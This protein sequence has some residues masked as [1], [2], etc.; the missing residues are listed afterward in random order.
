M[1]GR[2]GVRVGR[3]GAVLGR[4][5]GDAQPGANV[6]VRIAEPL[7]HVAIGAVV[8]GAE[9]GLQ[10]GERELRD[11][12]PVD[13]AQPLVAEEGAGAAGVGPVV[14]D[15]L[16]GLE[17]LP[18]VR[19]G[20][21][22]ACVAKG[23]ERRLYVRLV[24]EGA[25]EVDAAAH[26]AHDQRPVAVGEQ[27]LEEGRRRDRVRRD[28]VLVEEGGKLAVRV[29]AVTVLI[30][31]V[32][33]AR[34]ERLQRIE[35]VLG[36]EDAR[37]E[38]G[39]LALQ[40]RVEVPD[41]DPVALRRHQVVGMEE[42]V[43][44]AVDRDGVVR[45]RLRAV[46]QGADGGH[47]HGAD[48]AGKPGRIERL[49]VGGARLAERVHDS[50]AL[51]VGERAVG[52]RGVVGERARDGVQQVRHLG[53][54]LD[55]VVG[56]GLEEVAQNVQHAA[57][58]EQRH[59]RDAVAHEGVVGVVPL[60]PLGVHPDAALGDQI[61]QLGEHRHQELLG[62]RHEADL[63]VGVP[64]Q[65]AVRPD[66]AHAALDLRLQVGVEH[67][68][69]VRIAEQVGVRLDAVRD[70][71][72]AEEAPREEPFQPS[73]VVLTRQHEQPEQVD[74]LVIAPVPDVR[75]RVVGLDGLPVDALVRDAVRVVAVG[76]GGVDERRDDALQ[77]AGVRAAERLP[78]LEDV[79]PVALVPSLPVAVV[80]LD[81]DG[82][83]VPGTAGVAVAAAEAERQVRRAEALHLGAGFGR[84]RVERA[85][86]ETLRQGVEARGVGARERCVVMGDVRPH[87][88]ADDAVALV[89][90]AA[91]HDV[92]QHVHAVAGRRHRLAGGLLAVGARD[93]LAEPLR[94]RLDVRVDLRSEGVRVRE[95]VGQA[96]HVGGILLDVG[97]EVPGLRLARGEGQRRRDEVRPAL[98]A[99]GGLGL[100]GLPEAEA[101]ELAGGEEHRVGRE[102]GRPDGGR[103]ERLARL[104]AVDRDR[105]QE[106]QPERRVGHEFALLV[107]IGQVAAD[108]LKLTDEA[109][110]H[111]VLD[112]V[113]HAHRDGSVAVSDQ[114][115]GADEAEP[116]AGG[117]G[118]SERQA[119]VV[120]GLLE[121]K[122][123]SPERLGQAPA[124]RVQA[125]VPVRE[126][127]PE[128]GL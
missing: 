44:A 80:R 97:H 41:R 107:R 106:E 119:E 71:G 21:R 103:L 127:L 63:A 53:R 77:V 1:T 10:R 8:V 36:R 3:E 5:L 75:P 105:A 2:V 73:G 6:V 59:H 58:R 23:V 62:E 109:V 108:C 67:D 83:V 114:L 22:A 81:V 61:G 95:A 79:A 38:R 4:R 37:V 91:P 64:E 116:L 96:D 51:G 17:D 12:V 19:L 40:H 57:E 82:E 110:R 69:V 99:D 92:E 125:S 28:V 128:G 98:G 55:R 50:L 101:V 115:G 24:A 111:E 66:R 88:L 56:R 49:A 65:L 31:T 117:P 27:R 60:G 13:A 54:E 39:H 74:Q 120:V 70:V 72:V 94:A 42:A 122:A 26:V 7:E 112:A 46:H 104:G 43:V 15:G 32:D 25:V 100:D 47:R 78:V 30:G 85:D 45:D 89:E 29:E 84:H 33:G 118:D 48:V 34:A 124:G 123:V 113:Q 68:R 90:D 121:A 76:R 9:G 102:P 126:G 11:H 20:H 16:E 52:Q 86:G 93:E 18:G 87:V 14:E 35:R